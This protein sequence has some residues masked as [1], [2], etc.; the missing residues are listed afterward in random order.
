[1]RFDIESNRRPVHAV[2]KTATVDFQIDVVCFEVLDGSSFDLRKG[3]VGVDCASKKQASIVLSSSFDT[4]TPFDFSFFDSKKVWADL[5]SACIIEINFLLSS[6]NIFDGPQRFEQA[7]F[8]GDRFQFF[9]QHNFELDV[10]DVFVVVGSFHI[11]FHG[12]EITLGDGW[13]HGGDGLAVHVE[14]T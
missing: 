3:D 8:P 5:K 7:R 13:R 11:A 14:P 1:M 6:F 9:F 12:L 4:K 2:F 10:I